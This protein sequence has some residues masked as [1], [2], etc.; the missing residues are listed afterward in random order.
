MLQR[1]TRTTKK[2][3][4]TGYQQAP[5]FFVNGVWGGP[6]SEKHIVAHFLFRH[7]TPPESCE[8]DEEGHTTSQDGILDVNE[9]QVTL[10][11]PP[12]EAKSIAEWMIRHVETLTKGNTPPN[13][14][15][16]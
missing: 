6:L 5:R 10:I 14:T 7:A 8:F 13:T 3:I 2:V 9:V 4:Y 12:A 16:Q 15:M 11:I 1:S